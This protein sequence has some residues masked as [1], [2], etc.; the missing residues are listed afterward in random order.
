M[1]N[2][3]TTSVLGMDPMA[4]SMKQA[5]RNTEALVPGPPPAIPI[6][7]PEI[8][9]NLHDIQHEYVQ[10]GRLNLPGTVGGIASN[11]WQT[12]TNHPELGC[13]GEAGALCDR[14]QNRGPKDWQF[15]Y[16]HGA[17][18]SSPI[19]LPHSWIDATDPQGQKYR[20]DPWAD[21]AKP[22]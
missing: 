18:L 21:K 19:L 13:T 11:I 8:N 14:L 17:G 4:Y 2:D 20:V 9:D 12:F 5:H 10:K 7:L 6:G 22:I 3:K 16:G 15:K 1:P